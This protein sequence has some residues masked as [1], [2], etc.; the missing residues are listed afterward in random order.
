MENK[1][2]TRNDQYSQWYSHI[3]RTCYE[4]AISLGGN[5]T[6]PTITLILPSLAISRLAVTEEN[7]RFPLLRATVKML[8]N[9][10]R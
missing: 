4:L 1:E 10:L 5:P 3:S 7:D 9:R 8:N 2:K 6:I